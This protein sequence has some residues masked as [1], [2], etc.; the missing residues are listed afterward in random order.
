[1]HLAEIL[2]FIILDFQFLMMKL[3]YVW[4]MEELTEKEE[5]KLT[6]VVNGGPYVMTTGRQMQGVLSATCWVS[7]E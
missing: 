3:K 5:L 6:L 4:Q 2:I 7:G 1:M